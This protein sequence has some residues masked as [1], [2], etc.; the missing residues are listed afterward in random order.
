MSCMSVVPISSPWNLHQLLRRP[1]PPKPHCSSSF[2]FTPSLKAPPSRDFLIVHSNG[3]RKSDGSSFLSD[4][5]SGDMEGFLDSLSL[6]Y[7][8]VWDTKPS[9][10]QP[11]TILL[12]GITVVTCSW[13][14]LHS[15]VISIGAS[16]IICL[17]WY[18]F[19]YS[20]PK[21]YSE[22]I[23]ERRKKVTSGIEDT[24]GV[25]KGK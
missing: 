13:L 3:G 15:A 12:T 2:P 17:W 20:Y 14:F 19:L 1:F 21:A 10:C 9:W 5:D 16:S 4:E 11:W 18:I 22:M 23:A 7:D 6:E 24:F 8:S 25:R